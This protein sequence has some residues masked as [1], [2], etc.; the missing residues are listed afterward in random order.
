VTVWR[1]MVCQVSGVFTRCRGTGRRGE[2]LGEERRLIKGR[3][4]IE[5]SRMVIRRRP[6]PVCC[7]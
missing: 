4:S 3:V 1:L 6:V 2:G 5:G 7:A